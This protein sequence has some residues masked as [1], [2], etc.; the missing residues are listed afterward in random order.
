MSKYDLVIYFK[1]FFRLCRIVYHTCRKLNLFYLYTS[2]APIQILFA[3]L[4]MSPLLLWNS[5]IYLL[6]EH[7]CFLSFHDYRSVVWSA[8]ATYA[9][10]LG[11]LFLIY[12]RITIFIRSQTRLQRLQMKRRE[13]RDLI[14][15]RCI[16]ITVLLLITMG[17]PAI[18][19]VIMYAVNG[20]EHPLMY[21]VMWLFFSLSMAGLSVGMIFTTPELKR[22]LMNKESYH[23]T[24]LLHPQACCDRNQVRSRE[25][26]S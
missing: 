13:R 1:A 24:V 12:I 18:V 8:F 2:A 15:I 6:H 25:D 11:L 17:F 10:P 16:F 3:F 9:I 20:Q 26:I 4:V 21:R 22:I 14:A 23:H 5:E 19:F 7:Y